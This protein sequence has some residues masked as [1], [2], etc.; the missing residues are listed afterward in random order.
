MA[1]ITEET[2]TTA[3]TIGTARNIKLLNEGKIAITDLHMIST[4]EAQRQREIDL[5]FLTLKENEN[6][7][8]R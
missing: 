1:T 4:K 3:A 2:G 5:P 8:A 7:S 6:Y